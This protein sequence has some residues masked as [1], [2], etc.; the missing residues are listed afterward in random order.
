MPGLLS[1]LRGG[2]LAQL[3]AQLPEDL[4]RV[5]SGQQTEAHDHDDGDQTQALA[6]TDAHPAASGAL[7]A[8]VFHV[9]A[10]SAFFPKHGG[11][12]CKSCW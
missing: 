9:V 7:I 10:T 4:H 12:L 6:T 5:L 2:L 11:F 1:D 8:H 3:P